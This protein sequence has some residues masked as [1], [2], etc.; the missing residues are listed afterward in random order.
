MPRTQ[1]RLGLLFAA[2]CAANGAFVPAFAKLTTERADPFFVAAATTLFAGV[3]AA[4]VLGLRGDLEFLVGRGTGPR[5]FIVG[6]LGTA[7]AFL[8]FFY[9]AQRTTAIEAVLCLQIEPAYSLVLSWMFLGHRPT[10]RRVAAIGV[11][12][13]GITLAVGGRGVSPSAGVWA[14]LITP[15]CWQASH[16]VVLRRL[17]GVSPHVLTGARYVDGGLVLAIAWLARGG[18]AALP[19]PAQLRLLLPLLALQGIILSY[20]GTLLWYQAITRL[21]LARS[22]AIVVPSIPLLSLGASFLLLGEVPTA[23]QWAGL[24][25]TAAGVCAFVTAPQMMTAPVATV[26]VA[27]KQLHPAL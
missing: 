25:L 27:D 1:E 16:L 18:V 8:L 24:L 2:L 12:L 14:L 13:A 5:L 10:P 9:G 11:L 26:A 23:Y 22:T 17:T 19:E 7:C 15:L 6:T 4:L 21:D 3:F 20:V